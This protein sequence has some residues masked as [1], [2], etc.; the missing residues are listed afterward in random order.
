MI[1]A[2]A[3]QPYDFIAV[4]YNPN[5]TNDAEA[6]AKRFASAALKA[7]FRVKLRA[8]TRAGHA[9]EMAREFTLRYQRPLLIAASGDGGYNEVINGVMDAKKT[10]ATRRPVVAII[11]AGNANDHKRLTRGN[12]PLITLLIRNKPKPL[13]LLH[14]VCGDVDRYAH[15][16]IGLGI[17]PEVGIELNRHQLN[18]WRET[19]IVLNAFRKFQPFYI[20]R[21]GKRR[22]LSSLIFANL[23]GMAKVIK[24]DTEQNSLHDGKFEVITFRY[25]GK[26]ILLLDLLRSVVRGNAKALQVAE[27]SFKT[28]H[29]TAIQLDGEIET[30]PARR[31]ATVS[32]VQT[33]IE[34]LY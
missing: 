10:D 22:K 31:K 20:E 15:S 32:C 6:K 19:L 2:M 13:E 28:V 1:R 24:L 23:P 27:Y 18:R 5:S 9:R 30:L 26:F 16:Y 29:K 21:S 34:S 3:K 25:R 8:T 12:T 33:A 4:I 17:T 11:A 7:R 14:I